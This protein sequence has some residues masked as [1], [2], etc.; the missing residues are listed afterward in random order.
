MDQHELGFGV[1]HESKLVTSSIV[2]LNVKC[3]ISEDV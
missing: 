1:T 3:E 2:V